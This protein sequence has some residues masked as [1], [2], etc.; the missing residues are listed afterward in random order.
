MAIRNESWPKGLWSRLHE[1]RWM[2]ALYI[3]AY[4]CVG[5]LGVSV[6]VEPPNSITGSIGWL[7]YIWGVFSILGGI[8][9][10][11]A[12]LKGNW[13]AEK[14]AVILCITGI[15]IYA[16]TVFGLHFSG[17]GNRIPQA[18]ALAALVMN[19]GGRTVYI[20]P[21]SYEPGK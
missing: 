20:W 18:L 11:I 17:T 3:G 16:L 8:G 19:L 2:T 6:V 12:C 4:V 21:F 5:G 15:A 7:A 1:P 13:D 14:V 10:A 9:G